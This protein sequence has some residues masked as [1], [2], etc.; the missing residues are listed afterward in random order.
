MKVVL[1]VVVLPGLSLA[2]ALY[3]P[4]TARSARDSV[5][6]RPDIADS[7]FIKNCSSCHGKNGRAKTFKAKFNHAQDLS[8][9]K[10]QA[11]ITDEHMFVSILKGKGKMPAFRKKLSENDIGALV[12][13]VRMLK[14]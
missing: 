11:S 6:Q 13:Y 1:V 5:P 2:F 14:R 4:S 9:P 3:A 7:L 12:T 8:N 10:W